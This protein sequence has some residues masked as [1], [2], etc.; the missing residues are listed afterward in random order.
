MAGW[1][2]YDEE[3]YNIE[4]QVVAGRLVVGGCWRGRLTASGA[5]AK[6]M[7]C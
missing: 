4:D 5:N 6:Q 7:N 2:L 3:S 1:G